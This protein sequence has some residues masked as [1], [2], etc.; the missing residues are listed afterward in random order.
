MKYNLVVGLDKEYFFIKYIKIM[1][2]N[3][4]ETTVL[5]N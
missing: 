4:S 2:E 3:I 1:T 5:I